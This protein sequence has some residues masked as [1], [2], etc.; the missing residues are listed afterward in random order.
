MWVTERV[1][2]CPVQEKEREREAIILYRC[3]I[4]D[5]PDG[6]IFL[7]SLIVTK[8]VIG[9]VRRLENCGEQ[10]PGMCPHPLHSW[11]DLVTTLYHVSETV[12]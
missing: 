7:F 6:I 10:L 8:N 3:D 4:C 9:R 1:L 11:H 5:F 12:K 2:S